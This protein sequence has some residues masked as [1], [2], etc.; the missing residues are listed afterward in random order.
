MGFVCRRFC[1]HRSP[2]SSFFR[3]WLMSFFVWRVIWHDVLESH[4]TVTEQFHDAQ[5]RL[6]ATQV[7]TIFMSLFWTVNVLGDQAASHVMVEGVE[8]F[9]PT[10]AHVQDPFLLELQ[11]KKLA[12]FVH[13]DVQ[14]VPQGDDHGVL[15]G[16]QWYFDDENVPATLLNATKS[17]SVS[18]ASNMGVYHYVVGNMYIQRYIWDPDTHTVSHPQ[19]VWT[20][21]NF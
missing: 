19:P 8:V 7:V 9:P 2:R 6:L 18:V 21:T 3:A 13:P 12:P 11:V 14:N 17:T 1:A 5:G 15:L 16:A 20:G 4:R 10:V